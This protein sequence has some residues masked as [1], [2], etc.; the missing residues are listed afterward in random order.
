MLMPKACQPPPP[1]PTQNDCPAGRSGAEP[2]PARSDGRPLQPTRRPLETTPLIYFS[3]KCPALVAMKFP[4]YP[5]YR[6][7]CKK[8]EITSPNRLY[9]YRFEIVVACRRLV[10]CSDD[11]TRATT[12]CPLQ[13]L[14]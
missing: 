1:R 4:E 10:M 9:F 8:H 13:V 5:H 2:C 14:N 11:A 3:S 7:L 6:L 12:T